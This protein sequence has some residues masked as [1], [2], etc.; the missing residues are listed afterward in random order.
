VRITAFEL[1]HI[2]IPFRNGFSH[3]LQARNRTEAVIVSACSETGLCGFGEILPRP[4]LTGETIESVLRNEADRVAKKLLGL[5]FECAREVVSTLSSLLS[6]ADRVLATFAGFEIAVLDLACKE[7]ALAPH[8]LLDATPGPSLPGGV[9]I[10]FDVQTDHLARHCGMLRLTGQRHVKVKVG[11]DDDLE[12]LKIIF[13]TLGNTAKIRIDANGAWNETEAIALLLKMRVHPIDSV[14]QPVAASNLAGMRAVRE[15]TGL[16]VMV[17]ESLCSMA[18]AKTILEARA[19][20]IFNIRLGKCGGLLASGRLAE[21][22]R[23]EG[24]GCHL[25][26][27]VGET[28]IL[29]QAAELFGRIQPGFDYLEGKGQTRSLLE[30]DI[31]KATNGVPGLGYEVDADALAR[32]RISAARVA[33]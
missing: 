19:A 7:F 30:Q 28:G 6:P 14:E 32:F 24:L 25:G 13:D 11:R 10:A 22:A 5:N 20:D 3:A 23:K 27:L 33:D 31:T 15:A 4:Y 17:D 9:V 29:S 26:T 8:Q 12:R 1:H 2:S 16:R 18:D 21:L